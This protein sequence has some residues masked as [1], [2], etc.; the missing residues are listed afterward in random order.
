MVFYISCIN[1]CMNKR[2]KQLEIQ[3]QENRDT[4]QANAWLKSQGLSAENLTHLNLQL[5]QAQRIAHNCLKHHGQLL[6]ADEAQ[7]LNHFL[8]ALQ[9]KKKRPK[10][11]QAQ[12]FK[13]MNIGASVNRRTFRHLRKA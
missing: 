2:F 1:K 6:L 5:L 13:I 7:V 10:L 8:Q 12:A 3:H 11:T 9:S 4:L